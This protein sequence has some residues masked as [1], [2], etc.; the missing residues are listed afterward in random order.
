MLAKRIIAALDIKEGR[1]VKG[2]NFKNLRDAGDP[3]QLAKRYEDEGIDEIVFLDITASNEKRGILMD[4]VKEVA[5]EVHVPFTVGG[6]LKDLQGVREL[7]KNGADKV[8]IN[9]A[10]F[11]EPE[12][13]REVSDTLGSSN[14]VIAVDAKW[15]GDIWEVYTHGGSVPGGKDVI[16]WVREVEEL[17]GGEILLTSMDAD[18]TEDGFDIPML[19]AVVEAV[20]IPVI[21]SGG[22][23]K[24]EHFREAFQVDASGALAASIFHYEK[25]TVGDLKGYLKGCGVDV[26][27]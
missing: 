11:Q 13:I 26:R 4:I 25:Y 16:S 1:V 3:V 19:K 6:G 2:I 22:A 9:T 20:N 14:L 8:F 23:G 24:P 15:N 7:V 17:G 18:G 5:E 27:T 10:A 21:A 12:L